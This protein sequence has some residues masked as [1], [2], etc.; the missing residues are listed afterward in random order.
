MRSSSWFKP[1]AAFGQHV[2]QIPRRNAPRASW[3]RPSCNHWPSSR[4]MR[5]RYSFDTSR[6]AFLFGRPELPLLPQSVGR[7]VL[8][9]S[10]MNN[11]PSCSVS[12]ARGSDR[13]CAVEYCANA[14]SDVRSGPLSC[15]P[16]TPSRKRVNVVRPATVGRPRLHS[17][18][19]LKLEA[20]DIATC[21][22]FS[23]ACRPSRHRPMTP[24]GLVSAYL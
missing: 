18:A 2:V 14:A 5:C 12:H 17:C 10:T 6:I 7:S 21:S 15:T 4:P 23:P 24:S 8:S 11:R 16:R 19:L 13:E 22:Q 9:L 3:S 1:A 20:L